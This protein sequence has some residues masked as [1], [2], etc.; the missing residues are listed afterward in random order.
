MAWKTLLLWKV[1]LFFFFIKTGLSG[2]IPLGVADLNE[3]HW[4]SLLQDFS[5]SWISSSAFGILKQDLQNSE[6]TSVFEY[7][8]DFLARQIGRV[9]YKHTVETILKCALW[10]P[11]TMHSEV[12]VLV[13]FTRP[14][15]SMKAAVSNFW[16]L[17]CMLLYTSQNVACCFTQET[18]SNKSKPLLIKNLSS[19][20]WAVLLG[21]YIAVGH[22]ALFFR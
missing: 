3:V 17:Y 11:F 2:Q 8:L 5:E 22:L 15:L 21:N 13:M 19:A 20:C 6:L 4:L 14:F 1:G 18:I 10:H 9:L 7:R 12:F 16:R